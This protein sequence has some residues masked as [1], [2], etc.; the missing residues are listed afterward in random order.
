MR[1]VTESMETFRGLFTNTDVGGDSWPLP[2]ALLR[3]KV[4]DPLSWSLLFAHRESERVE[5]L[6]YD[7]VR[8]ADVRGVVA[9]RRGC[10]QTS[11]LQ[12]AFIKQCE[13]PRGSE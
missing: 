5:R 7:F 3:P 1:E 11:A 9:V 12:L 2:L 6:E 8:G 10:F 13:D 4:V